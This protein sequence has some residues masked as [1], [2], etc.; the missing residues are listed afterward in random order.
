MVISLNS[1][2]II[3]VL[4]G[5]ALLLTLINIVVLYF[6]FHSERRMVEM[7]ANIFDFDY[8]GTVPA[9][10]YRSCPSLQ[11]YRPCDSLPEISIQ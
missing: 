2:R 1:K 4:L 6:G 10:F 7:L 8:E 3:P 11:C 9:F 5:T